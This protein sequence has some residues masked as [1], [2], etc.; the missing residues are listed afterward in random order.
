[1]TAGITKRLAWFDEYRQLG[2]SLERARRSGHFKV[3]DA[4]GI[5]VT[6]I[7]ASPSDHRAHRN[8]QAVLRRYERALAAAPSVVSTRLRPTT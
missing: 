6:T 2:Y 4:S 3:R 5:L 8:A 1:M 7:A